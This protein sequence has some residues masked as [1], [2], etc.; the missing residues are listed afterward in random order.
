[1][2]ITSEGTDQSFDSLRG[3][4]SWALAEIRHNV[5]DGNALMLLLI[6]VVTQTLRARPG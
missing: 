6:L 1:M 2:E 4:H 3:R 5:T